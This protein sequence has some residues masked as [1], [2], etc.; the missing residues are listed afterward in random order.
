[1]NIN[2]VGKGHLCTT[3]QKGATKHVLGNLSERLVDCRRRCFRIGCKSWERPG[4]VAASTV[5]GPRR[6]SMNIGP[7][8]NSRDAPPSFCSNGISCL[9]AGGGDRGG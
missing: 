3:Y 1:M 6:D 2:P 7:L 5:G 8:K 4:F 9:A